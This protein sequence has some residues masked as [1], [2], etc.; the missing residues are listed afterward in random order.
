MNDALE[1][2]EQHVVV[3]GS[4]ERTDRNQ[5]VTAGPVLDHDGAAPARRHALSRRRA[6]ASVAL[7]APNGRISLTLRCAKPGPALGP[8]R[9]IGLL[10]RRARPQRRWT[11]L[12]KWAATES[13]GRHRKATTA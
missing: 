4:D 9:R 2:V 7:P 1:G 12:R 6:A 13:R 5:C 10:A 8:A 11:K 3:G